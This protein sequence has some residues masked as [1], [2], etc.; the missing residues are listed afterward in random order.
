MA[1]RKRGRPPRR[2]DQLLRGHRTFRLHEGLD[3]KLQEASAAIGRSISEEIEFRLERS[4]YDDQMAE[5][6]LG[7]HLAGELLRLIRGAMAFEAMPE[8]D[9]SR[10]PER[11]DELRWAIHVLLAITMNRPL[12]LPESEAKRTGIDLAAYLL[13]KSSLR[14]TMPPWLAD[15]AIEVDRTMLTGG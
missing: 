1:K 13:A 5:R 12:E 8:G 3:A 9:W 14:G 11:A 10:D 15:I 4:F 7:A 2:P 6:F